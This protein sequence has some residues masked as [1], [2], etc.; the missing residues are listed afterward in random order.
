MGGS[1]RIDG[2]PDHFALRARRKVPQD[3]FD[4]FVDAFLAFVRVADRVDGT[5]TGRLPDEFFVD[6]IKGRDDERAHGV[7]ALGRP[8]GPG[9]H[10][11]AGAVGMPSTVAK[12]AVRGPI[13]GAVFSRDVKSKGQIGI[14]DGI[15]LPQSFRAQLRGNRGRDSLL[16]ESIDRRNIVFQQHEG[17]GL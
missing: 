7:V 10:A 14:V 3:T 12:A 4:F 9:G 5:C 11:P 15:D 1:K 13:G 2:L 8:A 17:L 16:D 6:R